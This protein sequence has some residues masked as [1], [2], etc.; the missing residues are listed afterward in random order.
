LFGSRVTK[1][2]AKALFE[3]AQ[4]SKQIEQ[5]EED[6]IFVKET[7]EKSDDFSR[8]LISPV[9]QSAEKRKIFAQ[10]FE[11]KLQKLALEFL[12]LLLDKGREKM[13]P[14]II[15]NFLRLIDDSRGVLRGQLFT[16]HNFS[17]TQIQ[18]LKKR[19]DKITGKK[20]ILA[21]Q[22]DP[23]LIGGFVVRLD[24]TVIDTSIKNQLVKMREYMISSG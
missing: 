2:Y 5:I 9:I 23:S 4:E 6:L 3:A 10:L 19:L 17:E 1:R 11:Q 24:D 20:V 16:A 15:L 12:N 7:I 21:E 14:D 8:F 13:L 22:V 18:S